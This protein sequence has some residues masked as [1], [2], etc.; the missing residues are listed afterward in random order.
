MQVR[1]DYG[2]LEAK[3]DSKVFN[4]VLVGL[5]IE[6]LV[7]DGGFRMKGTMWDKI[8]DL[9]V[10]NFF[11]LGIRKVMRG[12]IRSCCDVAAWGNAGFRIIARCQLC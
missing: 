4:L 3:F 9:Q 5:R 6:L 12:Y 8:Y 1:V 11:E 7:F 10:S 2:F